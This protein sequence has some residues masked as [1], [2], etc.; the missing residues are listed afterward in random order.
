MNLRLFLC[1]WWPLCVVVNVICAIHSAN[2]LPSWSLAALSAAMA[3][4]SFVLLHTKLKRRPTDD[5]H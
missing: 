5:E 2:P 3:V 4:R 1:S